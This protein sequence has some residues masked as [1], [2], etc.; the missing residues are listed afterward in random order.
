MH[1]YI[2][3][4]L[5]DNKYRK[6]DKSGSSETE[7]ATAFACDDTMNPPDLCI[8]NGT[9]EWFFISYG[10]R[11]CLHPIYNASNSIG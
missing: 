10:I 3:V 4:I 9:Y 5:N 7:T 1:V 2:F 11:M 8:C 6:S